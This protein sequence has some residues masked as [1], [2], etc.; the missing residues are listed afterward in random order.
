MK[1]LL[2][3]LL[4]AAA[5]TANAAEVD[6]KLKNGSKLTGGLLVENDQQIVILV[7]ASNGV[8]RKAINKAD[9][10][11]V[12][13]HAAPKPAPPGP[14]DMARIQKNIKSAEEDVRRREAELPAAQQALDD[15]Y[16]NR[17]NTTGTSTQ[18]AAADS[19]EAGLRARLTT[20]RTQAETARSRL[21][22]LYKELEEATRQTFQSGQRA[23]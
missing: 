5:V 1:P 9:I 11:E 3:L 19:R 8:Y 10:A 15:F 2:I 22:A 13:E 23:K 7:Q 4:L 14:K 18:R 17:S 16:R 20:V 12:R 21:N 6:I